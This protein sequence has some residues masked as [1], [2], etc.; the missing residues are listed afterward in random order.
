MFNRRRFLAAGAAV[1]GAAVAV[2]V[3]IMAS[4]ANSAEADADRNQQLRDGLEPNLGSPMASRPKVAFT[5]ALTIPPVLAPTSTSGGVDAYQINVQPATVHLVPGLTTPGAL[6]FNGSFV[7][8]T[9][10]A[11]VNRPSKVTVTN[12][13]TDPITVHLHGGHTEAASDGYPMDLIQPGQSRTNNYSNT[14]RGTM[15]WYHDHAMGMEASHVYHGMHGMYILHD[16]IEDLLN[17]PSG[18]YDVPLM[19]RDIQLD[20]SGNMIYDARG[21]DARNT[22]LV[23]GS[24]Q[25]YF[26]VA[27]RKYRF[28]LLNAANERILQLSLGGS[29]FRQIASDGG[30]LPAPVTMTSLTLGSAERADIVIDFSTFAL[31]TSVYLTDTSGQLLRFD[32][33]RSEK[34]TSWCPN[35]LLPLPSMGTATATREV[36]MKF[37]FSN[38]GAV[39]TINGAAFDPNVINYTVKRGATEI[40]EISNDDV[41]PSIDHSFHMHLVQFRV[42]SRTGSPMLPDDIG[43]KDTIRVPPGTSVKVQAT[44]TTYLGKYVFHCH[45]LE[46]SSAGMMGQYEVVA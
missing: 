32:V 26:Q 44:Y 17:L 33:V 46:H 37:D 39:P 16:P 2:P 12:H 6:T 34:E 38:G 14:Q 11:T 28:R 23:N 24:S 19:I 45:Y 20:A 9:I 3:G 36:S 10:K 22:I 41:E 25:P 5:T 30:L 1:A 27:N 8:P 18:N 35:V 43:L 42:L 40:W 13:I 21:A 15:L 4:S 31:G 29:S 7:G